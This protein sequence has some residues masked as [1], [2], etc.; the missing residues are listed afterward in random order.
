MKIASQPLREAWR[1][2]VVDPFWR[3]TEIAD[4]ESQSELRWSGW[5]RWLSFVLAG[6]MVLSA[7]MFDRD[8]GAA[9]GWNIFLGLL[10]FGTIASNHRKAPLLLIILAA[11]TVLGIAWGSSTA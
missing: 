3:L 1:A 5:G 10:L 2:D 8:L 11:R 9:A 7:P 4:M 6:F